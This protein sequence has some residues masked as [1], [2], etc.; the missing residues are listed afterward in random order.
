MQAT[1]VFTQEKESGFRE[2]RGK[3]TAQTVHLAHGAKL[4]VHRK[5]GYGLLSIDGDEKYF[6]PERKVRK[7]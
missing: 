7:D 6:I 1:P 4:K 5:V 2:Q 3:A